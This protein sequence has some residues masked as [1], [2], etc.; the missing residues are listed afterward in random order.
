MRCVQQ[1]ITRELLEHY[2]QWLFTRRTEEGKPLAWGTQA[3]KLIALKQWLARTVR[4]ERLPCDP[5]AD[6]ELP[7]LPRR[8]PCSV[9]SARE[10]EAVFARPDPSTTLGLRD[11]ALLEVLY[12]TGIRRAELAHLLL[13]DVDFKRG[14]LL[15]RVGSVG[16][17][18]QVRPSRSS[19]TF[20]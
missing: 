10:A 14:I 3:Q 13:P 19:R 2:R 9:L 1:E 17:P 6:L 8:L 7:R 15:I 12:S 20:T 5:A 4:S 11:R 18:P 16:A